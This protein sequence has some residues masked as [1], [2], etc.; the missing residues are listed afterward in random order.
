I[1][2]L[3]LAVVAVL[4][5]LFVFR[6][7]PAERPP[8]E[9]TG[10]KDVIADSGSRPLKLGGDDRTA[11]PVIQEYAERVRIRIENTAAKQ[12]AKVI[13][14]KALYGSATLST[15]V[16]ADDGTV[17]RIEVSKTSGLKELD[18]TARNIVMRASPFPA[19]PN[20]LKKKT[21]VVVITR[22]F[23]FTKD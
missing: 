5:S 8:G 23:R 2:L 17:E 15:F 18:D 10:A 12:Y 20:E 19:P 22:E 11:D 4:L 9:F 14:D 6:F 21:D 16:R 13:R 1:A 7:T 3:C